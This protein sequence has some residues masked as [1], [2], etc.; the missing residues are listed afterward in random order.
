MDLARVLGCEAVHT[1]GDGVKE[2]SLAC[3]HHLDMKGFASEISG[4]SGARGVK[5]LQSR[6]GSYSAWP[7]LEPKRYFKR[8][9][10]LERRLLQPCWEHIT[11]IPG[12]QKI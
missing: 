10:E 12:P 7:Y 1:S 6:F 4:H 8:L 11:I 2:K 5:A 3:N 9:T